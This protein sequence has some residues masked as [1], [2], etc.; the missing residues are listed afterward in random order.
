MGDFRRT[1]LH[2]WFWFWSWLLG[3]M[4]TVEVVDDDSLE[5]EVAQE[6]EEDAQ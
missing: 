3:R 5:G 2:L 1:G 6:E 4:I